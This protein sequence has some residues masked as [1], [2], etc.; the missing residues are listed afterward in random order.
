MP[1]DV[2]AA[3]NVSDSWLFARGTVVLKITIYMRYCSTH[4]HLKRHYAGRLQC[5]IEESARV[6]IKYGSSNGFGREKIVS[7]IFLCAA[8]SWLSCVASASMND[9]YGSQV[10]A[11][12]QHNMHTKI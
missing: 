1:N 2:I 7:R 11:H 10:L 6:S 9:N 4:A 5:R 3:C 8:N 12:F